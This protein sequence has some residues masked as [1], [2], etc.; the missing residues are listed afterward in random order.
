M[1]GGFALGGWDTQGGY[2]ALP[3]ETLDCRRVAARAPYPDDPD[4][5]DE[6]FEDALIPEPFGG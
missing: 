5:A 1:T 6:C 4:N 2:V 3:G